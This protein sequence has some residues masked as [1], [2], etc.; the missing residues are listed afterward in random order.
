M[1]TIKEKAVN[2]VALPERVLQFGEGNFLRAF[3]DWMLHRMNSEDLFNGETVVVQ[4][5]EKGLVDLLNEQD[6][7]YTLFLRGIQD[8]K[9]INQH[10]LITSIS[11]GINP[12]KDWNAY[13]ETAANPDMRFVVSNTTEAG[14]V[15]V[16]EA[17]PQDQCPA[18]F[19]AKLTAWLA[20]RFRIFDGSTESGLV[21]LPC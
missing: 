20:E 19:P 9:E 5:L 21:F 11:R 17:R 15:Y 8:G 3:I 10:E 6:G 12:Y 13:L 16:Q 18:S 14:I 4:P 1:V 7:L 2:R